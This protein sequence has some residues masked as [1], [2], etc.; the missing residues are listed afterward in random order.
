MKVLN[1]RNKKPLGDCFLEFVW[2]DAGHPCT[3][4]CFLRSET[5]WW[6]S[7]NF[8]LIAFKFDDLKTRFVTQNLNL[9]FPIKKVMKI[10]LLLSISLLEVYNYHVLKPRISPPLYRCIKRLWFLF[11]FC[12][13]SLKHLF[14][15][16]ICPVWLLEREL[17]QNVCHFNLLVVQI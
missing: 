14:Q 13:V 2:T 1:I 15:L 9:Q 3:S 17:C 11:L 7:Q 5:F 16:I 4:L 8:C 12:S 6:V 10:V